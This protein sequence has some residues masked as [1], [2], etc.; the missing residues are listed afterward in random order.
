MRLQAGGCDAAAGDGE[1]AAAM[2]LRAGCCDA[3]AA[4]FGGERERGG[5]D[6]AS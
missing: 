4:R 2:R 6:A 5:G 3:G 1:R